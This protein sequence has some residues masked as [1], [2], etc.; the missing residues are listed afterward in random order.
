MQWLM[1]KLG[2]AGHFSL[3]RRHLCSE[4][5]FNSTGCGESDISSSTWDAAV[6]Q[7]EQIVKA[8]WVKW[9]CEIIRLHLHLDSTSLKLENSQ[10]LVQIYKSTVQE[11]SNFSVPSTWES[12]E[13]MLPHLVSTLCSKP[14]PTSCSI[15]IKDE[16]PTTKGGKLWPRCVYDL[17]RWHLSSVLMSKVEHQYDS[18]VQCVAFRRLGIEGT[19]VEA[20]RG[21]GCGP[22]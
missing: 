22:E 19:G 3:W 8:N 11:D 20:I 16:S 2:N 15:Q 17:V 9:V 14:S 10:E 18:G 12:F 13:L 5:D 7:G 6:P 4:D 1:E 21:T